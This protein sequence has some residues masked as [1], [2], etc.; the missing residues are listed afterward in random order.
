[1]KDLL[2]L[3]NTEI[4]EKTDA[5]LDEI[6]HFLVS[7]KPKEDFPIG[8]FS[9]SAGIALF[10]FYYSR[11]KKNEYFADKAMGLLS[12][13]ISKKEENL[14]HPFCGG[15]SGICWCIQHLICEGF[16]D[17][18]NIEIIKA[19]DRYLCDQVAYHSSVG[20]YDFLHGTIGTAL[21]L[22][23]RSKTPFV[24]QTTENMVNTLY[25]SK[26]EDNGNYYWKS[27]IGND[28]NICISHGISS[29][30]IYLCKVFE[31]NISKS[32]TQD[33][34]K[35]SASFLINQE[36]NLDN[37]ISMFPSFNKL[38]DPLH[39]RLGWCYGD[40]GIGIS[41]WHYAT[42]FNDELMKEKAMEIFMF[43]SKRKK[44]GENYV[45][46]AGICHGTAGIAQI[47]KKVFLH[48]KQ[49]EFKETAMFWLEQT[50]LMSKYSDGVV[51]YKAN[52][53][54]NTLDL[55]NGIAGIGL[56]FLSFLT[57]EDTN[58]DECLL[59]I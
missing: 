12:Y 52:E 35:K 31:A 7:L 34:A 58:W 19:F 49:V 10:L 11:Y 30:C 18:E 47:Y 2:I 39:S 20:N 45:F 3:Q 40:L 5:K 21:Y 59:L 53:K 14:Y 33:L 57:N 23:K 29:I 42:I 9:G 1:M 44:L 6:A 43:S 46:D 32:T 25:H 24:R 55:L 17:D 16:I 26:I 56:V 13:S 28:I 22:L 38:S 36:I 50:L 27:K 41:I 8:L 51:G 48:T 15:I 54:G 4:I 37:R